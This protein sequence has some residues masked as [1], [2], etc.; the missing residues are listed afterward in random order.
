MWMIEEAKR[1]NLT[2]GGMRGRIVLDEMSIQDD[3]QLV[4]KGESS[5]LV[6]VC[7]LGQMCNDILTLGKRKRMC[8]KQ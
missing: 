5:E 8:H 1:N 6:G 2:E 7:D 4:R 3:I